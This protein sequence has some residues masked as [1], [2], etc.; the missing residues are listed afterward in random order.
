MLHADLNAEDVVT[1]IRQMLPANA[2]TAQAI[3][4][5][6]LWKRIAT[7]PVSDVHVES[8]DE[9]VRLDEARELL[10]PYRARRFKDVRCPICGAFGCGSC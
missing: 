3:I 1:Q 8:A 7:K 9:L 4:P 2:A 10:A 5:H 6:A